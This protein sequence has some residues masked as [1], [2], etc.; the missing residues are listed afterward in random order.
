M[1][2][3][4]PVPR[5][6]Q[7]DLAKRLGVS[8][9]AVSQM[10]KKGIVQRE[11]DGTIF[12]DQAVDKWH[13]L[14]DVGP[15]RPFKKGGPKTAS[16]QQSVE[17][18]HK[19]RAQREDYKAKLAK[20]AYQEK[21]GNLINA[22]AARK[23]LGDAI[24]ATRNAMLTVPRTIAP[25]LVGIHDEAVIADTLYQALEIALL[26]LTKEVFSGIPRG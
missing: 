16:Y 21:A 17:R 24:V 3:T 5:G 23:H 19:A 20:L 15:Q 10:V 25:E 22:K 14:V 18:Y 7:S 2:D 26:S 9:Q 11:P 13:A 1:T 8:R 12:L 4:T 6:N